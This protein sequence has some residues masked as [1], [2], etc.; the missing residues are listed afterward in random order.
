MLI[1]QHNTNK[2]LNSFDPQLLYHVCYMV[3]TR[4]FSKIKGFQ[5]ELCIVD[6]AKTQ[7][8]HKMVRI[9]LLYHRIFFFFLH[10]ILSCRFTPFHTDTQWERAYFLLFWHNNGAFR[11]I[12]VP[13]IWVYCVQ[14]SVVVQV[15]IITEINTGNRLLYDIHNSSQALAFAFKL[16][17]HSPLSHIDLLLRCNTQS[18]L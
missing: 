13:F 2:T 7:T 1:S 14:W 17:R 18:S 4:W 11:W 9:S 5:T 8:F 6:G 12:S 10:S 15:L 16:R 3:Y